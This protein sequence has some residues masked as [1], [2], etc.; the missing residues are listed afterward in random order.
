[1]DNKKS[2]Q[3][4]PSNKKFSSSS[5]NVSSKE[6]TAQN[7]DN[8]ED[9]DL[10]LNIQDEDIIQNTSHSILYLK[11]TLT[12]KKNIIPNNIIY[13]QRHLS[14]PAVPKISFLKSNFFP[15]PIILGSSK[16]LRFKK[17]NFDD[18][19]YSE[20]EKINSEEESF[21]SDSSN[22]EEIFKARRLYSYAVEE[23]DE[24]FCLSENDKIYDKNQKLKIKILRK[25]MISSKKMF[26]K[27]FKIE[28]YKEMDDTK[29]NIFLKLKDKILNGKEISNKKNNVKLKDDKNTKKDKPILSF[30]KNNSSNCLKLEL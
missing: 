7:L 13:K 6:N 17:I 9:N 24:N 23:F 3:F 15:T 2:K 4:L 29:Q 10:Y 28:N 26:I 21:D 20:D 14:S 12:E 5:A 11:N 18:D 16:K 27:N 8:S 25:E 30:L 1:M 22:D 19:Y